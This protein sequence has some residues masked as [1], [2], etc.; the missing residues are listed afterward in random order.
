MDKQLIEMC[1]CEEIQ[2]QA[3]E[4]PEVR[5]GSEG[6]NALFPLQGARF[7]MP[8]EAEYAILHWDNDEG[9]YMIGGY[10][11]DEEGMLWLP[12][13][14]NIQEMLEKGGFLKGWDCPYAH[15]DFL[16][17]F[18]KE[19]SPKCESMESL[20]IQFYMSFH[21]KHWTEG[22]REDE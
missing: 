18:I 6:W 7:W 17:R 8:R 10:N 16:Q 15:V 5:G 20:Y 4:P 11:S 9:R 12:S 13:Q 1:D 14:E 21:N 2:K 19:K 22:G 3:P